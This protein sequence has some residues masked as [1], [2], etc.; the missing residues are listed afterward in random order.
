MQNFGAFV[1]HIAL[2]P[3]PWKWS[4]K[5]GFESKIKTTGNIKMLDIW[6]P[7]VRMVGN[8]M[9]GGDFPGT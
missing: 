6:Q 2:N 8:S 7:L 3:E 1:A 9:G 4:Q 5:S